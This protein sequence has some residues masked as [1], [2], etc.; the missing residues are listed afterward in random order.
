M[1]LRLDLFSRALAPG[2]VLPRARKIASMGACAIY[3][4]MT[5]YALYAKVGFILL[6]YIRECLIIRLSNTVRLCKKIYSE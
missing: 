4:T 5:T 1:S 2:N 3:S 6:V